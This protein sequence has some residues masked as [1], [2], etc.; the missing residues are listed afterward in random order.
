MSSKLLQ[1]MLD[2][3]LSKHPNLE[4]IWRKT[5]TNREPSNLHIPPTSKALFLP[6]EQI[7]K[8]KLLDI[9]LIT[10]LIY[11]LSLQFGY[12]NSQHKICL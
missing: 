11:K 7:V 9:M 10:I 1:K 6:I 4:N 12:L 8:Y 2:E 5:L 3:S